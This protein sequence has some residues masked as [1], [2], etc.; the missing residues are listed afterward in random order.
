M[1]IALTGHR[2]DKLGNEWNMDGPISQYLMKE[3]KT[4]LDKLKPD[5]VISGMALGADM[6]WAQAAVDMKVPFLAAVPFRGQE[7]KWPHKTQEYY[8]ELLSM[9]YRVV[10]TSD[11]EHASWKFQERNKKMVD[12]CTLL[13][14]VWDGTNGGTANCYKYAK[15][16]GREIHRIYLPWRQS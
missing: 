13:V 14:A 1:I 5:G 10:Y 11:G 4:I 3:F 16:I 15:S 2:P 12:A 8:R 7:S 6:I 9:A